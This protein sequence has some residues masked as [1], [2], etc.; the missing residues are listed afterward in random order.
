MN[1]IIKIDDEELRQKD[2]E[3]EFLSDYSIAITILFYITVFAGIFL[4][5]TY[6]FAYKFGVL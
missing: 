4:F 2:G 6:A 3:Q 5:F 1:K